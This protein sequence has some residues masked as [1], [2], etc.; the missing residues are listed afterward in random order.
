MVLTPLLAFDF[1]TDSLESLR[2]SIEGA[3]QF[4]DELW[5]NT[6]LNSSFGP[7][8]F[9][10]EIATLIAVIATA[11]FFVQLTRTSLK[12]NDYIDTFLRLLSASILL[13]LL[14][15]GARLPSNVVYGVRELIEGWNRQI[16]EVEINNTQI[17]AIMGDILMTRAS[18]NII[19]AEFDRCSRMPSPPIAYVPSA[20][21]SAVETPEQAQVRAKHQCFLDLRQTAGELLEDAN[22]S[23]WCFGFCTGLQR[24]VGRF[25][26][27]VDDWEAIIEQEE[28]DLPMTR[29]A[30]RDAR[31]EAFS[32]VVFGDLSA[33]IANQGLNI[34]QNAFLHFIELVFWLS[35]LTTP[36]VVAVSLFP[37]QTVK[38]IWT[39]LMAISASGLSLVYYVILT[40]VMAALISSEYTGVQSDIAF[41]LVFGLF[42]PVLAIGLATG[43]A[44]TAVSG[45]ARTA[46]SLIQAAVYTG[47][48]AAAALL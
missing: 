2:E 34:T 19:A 29:L 27:A 12:N 17:K 11:A 18:R 21:P 14:M 20:D 5:A 23:G 39:W 42:G 7:Y 1:S 24:F 25:E 48:T 37:I 47:A 9:V 13:I 28:A 3:G 30:G 36:I 8:Q 35:A 10:L 26:Q 38:P 16:L 43:T 33:R 44:L 31:L 45:M 22:N 6:F 46:A 40:S 41:G 15:N 32:Q 4:W